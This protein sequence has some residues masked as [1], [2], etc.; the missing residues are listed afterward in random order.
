MQIGDGVVIITTFLGSVA[1]ALAN[2]QSSQFLPFAQLLF[3]IDRPEE[4]PTEQW[5]AVSDAG[6]FFSSNFQTLTA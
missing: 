3:C 2:L 4:W 5:L 6:R 1:C